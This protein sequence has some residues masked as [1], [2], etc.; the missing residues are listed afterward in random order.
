MLPHPVN[1]VSGPGRKLSPV[2]CRRQVIGVN[3]RNLINQSKAVVAKQR[4]GSLLGF[5]ITGKTSKKISP[6]VFGKID[7][8]ICFPVW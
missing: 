2:I 1:K 8:D 7:K 5:I 3:K 4:E 6:V